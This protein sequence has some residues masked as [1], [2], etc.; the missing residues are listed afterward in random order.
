MTG[1]GYPE[2]TAA[3]P[4]DTMKAEPYA[5][6]P[7]HSSEYGITL[8]ELKMRPLG[9]TRPTPIP[10]FG[11]TATPAPPEEPDPDFTPPP[12]CGENAFIFLVDASNSMNERASA[13]DATSK[14]TNLKNA[15]IA[16][17]DELPD[18]ALFGL[19]T[20]SSP[21]GG[22]PRQRLPTNTALGVAPISQVRSQIAPA[23]NAINPPQKAATHMR[24]GFDFV[25]EK[26]IAAKEEN[27]DYLFNLIFI[28]DGVPEDEGGCREG[29][30]IGT[31][32]ENQQRGQRSY[33][34]LHDPTDQWG[35]PNYPD[36]PQ[37]IKDENINIQS[38][39]IYNP[40]DLQIY[41]EL[42]S[43]MQDISSGNESYWESE[44]ATDMLNVLEGIKDHACD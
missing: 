1:G 41:P 34:K 25:G 26:I 29:Y 42:K 9:R 3:Y 7:Q 16:F 43:L 17:S 33:D 21:A 44:G 30:T 6:Q 4:A 11:P 14:L 19:Y 31:C 23:L 32:A 2:F 8:R 35:I 38:I 39:V 40:N 37:R 20:F 12:I 5:V 28:S 24:E 15:I 13:S 18:S 22:D 10:T 36:I 27:P